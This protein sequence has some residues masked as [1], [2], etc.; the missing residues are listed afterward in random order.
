MRIVYVLTSLGMGGAERQVVALAGRM[1]ERGHAVAIIVLRPHLSEEWPTALDVVY[2]DMRRNPISVFAGMARARRFLEQFQPD[3]V[4]SHSFHANMIAR[5]LHLFHR[6][7]KVVSTVHNVYEGRLH[8]MVAYR[9]TD[10]LSTRTTAVSTA[11][12]ER[13]VRLQA[14]PKQK[15]LVV[16]NGIDTGE[17]APNTGRRSQARSATTAGTDFVWLTAGRIAPAKDIPNLL[18]AFAQ[19][20]AAHP[21]AQLWIAGEGEPTVSQQN[22]HWLGLRRDLPALL[23][24]ADGFVLASAWE[25]MPLVV[26]EAMAMEKPVVATDVGGVRELVGEAGVIVPAKNSEALAASMLALMR[27]TTE[28][29]RK[30][31]HAS[32]S[33]IENEFSIDSRADDW[34]ALYRTL[35]SGTRGSH[36]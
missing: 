27:Q 31:G 25:G 7:V 32:R 21:S 2:L 18:R 14:I 33:R 22:V 24:A 15:C 9:L 30:T 8:R 28:D 36:R 11:A 3:L 26:G 4:H 34:E 10:F 23:D 35:T 1:A 16:T 13:F 6:S 17:F 20:R 12:A 5:L 29:R 19:V